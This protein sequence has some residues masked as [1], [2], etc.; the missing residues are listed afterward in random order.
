MSINLVK[1]Q[2]ID[3]TKG[4]PGLQSILVGLGWDP[5]KKKGLFGGLK[6]DLDADASVLLL[7]KNGKLLETVY[8]GNLGSNDGSVIHSGDNL[9]G[10]GRGDDEQ[11]RVNLS[12]ISS[13]VDKLVFVVNIYS[14][15]MRNQDFGMVE[16]AFIRVEDQSK[17]QELAR[18]NLTEDYSGK[19]ALIVGEIY[20]HENEW[21]FAAIGEGTRD[22]SI[23]SLASQ[24]R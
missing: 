3:L 2:K 19:T 13:K 4:N 6:R 18:F 15:H 22:G 1:G 8:F 10:S 14:A 12:K 23:D 7:N 24:Y 5:V 9:T 16:N 21:K 17:D 11:I 20:R